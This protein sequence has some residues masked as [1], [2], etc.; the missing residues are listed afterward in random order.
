ML[1]G[2]MRVL[3]LKPEQIEGILRRL[4]FLRVESGDITSFTSMTQAEYAEDRNR[5]RNLERLAENIAN[6]VVDITKIVLE[7]SNLPAPST[8]REIV[9]CLPALGVLDETLTQRLA[10]MVRLR[11]I[12]AHEYL[13]I[14]W[15]SLRRFIDEAPAAV[16]EFRASIERLPGLGI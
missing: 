15:A 16:K 14:R 7:S 12:V 8:Y 4:E 1:F 2:V 6:S 11:N 10:N 9:L 3:T 5:R 13:D